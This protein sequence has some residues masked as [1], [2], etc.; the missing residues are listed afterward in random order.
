[1]T[2][3]DTCGGTGW[4]RTEDVVV[5]CNDCDGYGYTLDWWDRDGEPNPAD[6]WGP[7]DD[8]SAVGGG[9]PV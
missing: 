4:I 1:M 9:E 3:C 5:A 8:E 7:Y 2:I 6:D